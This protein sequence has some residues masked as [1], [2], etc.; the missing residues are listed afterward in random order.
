MNF[1]QTEKEIQNFAALKKRAEKPS[2]EIV[3]ANSDAHVVREKRSSTL[4]GVFFKPCEA[5]GLSVDVPAV[6]LLRQTRDG[7]IRVT[8]SDPE[9]DL[10]R[11]SVTL[12]WNGKNYKIN[13]PSG[14]YCGQPVT[15]E[16]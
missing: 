5:G 3:S 12:G 13:L 10:K 1:F 16:L 9:Q 7:K 2:F 14:T 8:D 11:D 4:A 15:T 6:V